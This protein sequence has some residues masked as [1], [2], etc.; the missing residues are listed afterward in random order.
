MVART[1]SR[2]R[3][4]L[5]KRSWGAGNIKNNRGSGDR[6]GVGKGGRKHNWTYIVKYE[7]ERMKSKGFNQWKQRKFKNIDLSGVSR[8]FKEEKDNPVI[9]LKG[10]KVLGDGMLKHAAVINAS[11]FSE[12]AKEKIVKAGGEFHI[13]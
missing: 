6:G 5:G 7:K 12:S 13:I 10:Y 9:D 11:S 4:L 2:K 8:M 3:K 1:K